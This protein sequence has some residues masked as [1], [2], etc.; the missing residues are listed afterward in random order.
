MKT[1]LVFESL[2]DRS[3][4]KNPHWIIYIFV[5]FCIACIAAI[6][7]VFALIRTIFLYI[8]SSLKF[9]FGVVKKPPELL[10][11][12]I[13]TKTEVQEPQKIKMT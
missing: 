5:Y 3:P 10:E 4:E 2:K 7:L 1:N 8:V 6:F 9:I 13:K 11:I 12:E